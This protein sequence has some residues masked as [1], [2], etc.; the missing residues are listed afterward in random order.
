MPA[1]KRGARKRDPRACTWKTSPS[2]RSTRLGRSGSRRM[3]SRPMPD[4]STRSP[5]TPMRLSPVDLLPG[6]CGKRLAHGLTHDEP[7]RPGAPNR[8]W[9]DWR[10]RGRTALA[11]ATAPWRRTAA[12]GRD[13]RGAAIN[14][15]AGPRSR[16]G[17]NHDTQP[18]RRGGPDDD[19]QPHRPTPSGLADRGTSRVGRTQ[20]L[21]RVPWEGTR[22][23]SQDRSAMSAWTWNSCAYAEEV[24]KG[25]SV[26]SR[27]QSGE[28]KGE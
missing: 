4:S 25:R 2:V 26:G 12:G 1:H 24:S 9:G 11:E 23:G 13:R 6:S 10:R 19:R 7:C 15:Q 5:S 18:S 8:R 28:T 20:C 21:Q 27:R 16:P 22:R 17:S 14:E 3:T